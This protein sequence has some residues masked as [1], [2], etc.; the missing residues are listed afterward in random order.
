MTWGMRFL[1]GLLASIKPSVFLNFIFVKKMI[2][3]KSSEITGV[4]TRQSMI[5]PGSRKVEGSRGTRNALS[6]DVFLTFSGQLRTERPFVEALM[7]L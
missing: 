7:R 1:E 2:V 6:L 3:P 5:G 4:R